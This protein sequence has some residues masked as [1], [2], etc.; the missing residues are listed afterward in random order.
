V[1]DLHVGLFVRRNELERLVERL[2][3]LEVD[4][5][6]VAGDWTFEPSHDLTATFAPL[7]RLRH[8][9]LSVLGNHDEATP[10]PPLKPALLKA[11]STFHIEPIDGRRVPLGRCE[12]EGLGD[13]NALSAERHLQ[14]LN[15]QAW[16][17]DRAHRLI[18]A[19]NP[20]TVFALDPGEVPL[21]LAGHTH[22]GQI[23]VPVLTESM[24]SHVTL[25]RFRQGLYEIA[26]GKVRVFVTS[27]VGNDKLPLRFRVPPTID[28]LDL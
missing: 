2:N 23:D 6:L 19:H 27:G 17:V 26:M 15:T 9:T 1:S 18:L 10:G 22:G 21:L 13:L 25:G 3:T 4:A 14:A 16:A 7:A 11:L 8:R 28:V 20:D 5:V 24:L 12:L